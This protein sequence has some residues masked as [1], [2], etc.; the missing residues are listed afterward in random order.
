MQ[1]RINAYWELEQQ[2]IIYCSSLPLL[3]K[4]T[5]TDLNFATCL[6]SQDSPINQRSVHAGRKSERIL[7]QLGLSFALNLECRLPG[8]QWHFLKCCEVDFDC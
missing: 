5:Q 4:Y 8:I 1:Y 7:N 2:T 3:H 6:E